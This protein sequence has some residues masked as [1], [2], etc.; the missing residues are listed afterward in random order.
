MSPA[1]SR[2]ERWLHG[3]AGFAGS[4]AFVTAFPGLTERLRFVHRLDARG[5]AAYVAAG[6]AWRFVLRRFALPWA[7]RKGAELAAF[8]AQLGR[9]PTDEELREFLSR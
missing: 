8:R 5:L 1:P 7:R 4:V 9:E 6:T 2:R 3:G